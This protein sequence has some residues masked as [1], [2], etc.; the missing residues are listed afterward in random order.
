MTLANLGRGLLNKWVIGGV[1]VILIAGLALVYWPKKPTTIDE[2]AEAIGIALYTRNTRA[3]SNH[4]FEHERV[5][6]G[7]GPSDIEKFLDTFLANKVIGEY[8]RTIS[9]EASPDGRVGQAVLEIKFPSGKL[10][11]VT[12]PAYK[13]PTGGNVLI[14]D[15]LLTLIWLSEAAAN[16][17]PE[18]DPMRSIRW[19]VVRDHDQLKA[20]G[21][22]G[23]AWVNPYQMQRSLE[24]VTNGARE[25]LET[26]PQ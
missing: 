25:W 26:N 9:K 18:P 20:L 14:G 12:V 4:I 23:F 22:K 15:T 10:D 16:P 13:T 17:T 8:V 24:G 19:R 3:L 5:Y 11:T 1:A 6:F 2:D 21:F 7:W